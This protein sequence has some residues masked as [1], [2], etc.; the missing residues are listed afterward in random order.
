MSPPPRKWK[1]LERHPHA[2]CR[3]F[4]IARHRCRHPES[5]KEGDFYIINAFDW[6]I[7][8]ALTPARELVLVNQYRF[9][10]EALSWEF[11]AGCIDK[12]ES[13][14]QAAAR[15]LREETGYSGKNARVIG[16]AHPNPALQS[17][18]AH[19]VLIEDARL[20]HPTAWGPNEEIEVAPVPIEKVYNWAE[21]GKINH[22]VMVNALFRFQPIWKKMPP[23]PKKK[24]TKPKPL[25]PPLA[26]IDSEQSRHCRWHNRT[27]NF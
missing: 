18:L 16:Q 22:S 23:L 3:V 25:T 19:F 9:G 2:D 14:V 5:K 4:H 10:T 15:E 27:R 24:N 11:P 12:G 13:P 7:I 17:N 26:K 21:T 6:A 1:T 20:T 8:L